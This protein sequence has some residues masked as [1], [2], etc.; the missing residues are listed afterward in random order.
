MKNSAA[1]LVNLVI[2]LLTISLSLQGQT[3]EQ[4]L[5]IV[6]N[7]QT[8]GGNFSIQVQVKGTSL[9]VANTLGSATIDVQF[10]NTHLNY[11]SATSWAFGSAQGYNRSATNNSTFIR[12][13]ITGMSV[14]QD[15]GGEPAGFD[16]GSTYTSWVQLNFTIQSLTTTS[17]TI[18]NITNAIGLFE[19]HANEPATGVIN[20]Q[21]LTTPEN[22]TEVTLPVELISFTSEFLSD[23]IKL[24]W[25]TKT[26]VNNYGFNIERRINGNEWS[27]IGFVEGNGNS[28]SLKEYI[29]IDKDLFAGGSKFYYRL[30]QIDTDGSFIYSDISEVT[31]L[32]DNFKLLQNYPNPFNPVTK[33][34][35]QSPLSGYHVLKVYDILGNE[36]TALVDEYKEAGFH[37]IE[38]DAS[39][40]SSGVYFYRFM[41]GEAQTGQSQVFGETKKMVLL[42]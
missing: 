23:K 8:I 16:I 42:K 40:L 25:I 37:T 11:V 27:S 2:L 38:F 32:P 30:K 35:W 39:G 4:K 24:N 31:V 26:E 22:I 34:S 3:I 17:L 18:N 7:T 5:V 10:D 12:I 15:G 9:P 36:V 19:N 21:I 20:N 29:Y 41:I 13:G 28:N 6:N 33:I 1:Y 14:N